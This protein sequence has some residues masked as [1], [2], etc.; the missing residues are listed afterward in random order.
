M[1]GCMNEVLNPPDSAEVPAFKDRRTGLIVFGVLQI[2]FGALC[3]LM[4]LLMILGQVM[5]SKMGQ[6]PLHLRQMIPGA[7][8]YAI[9]AAT[10][11]VLGIGSCQVR[12]GARALSLVVSWSW[13]VLGVVSL[14]AMIL[15]LPSILKAPQAQ[16][17]ALPETAKTIMLIVSLLRV[18]FV[19]SVMAGVMVRF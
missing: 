5:A 1:L 11:V 19:C 17:Q 8:F 3:V 9:A 12:R 6:A 2:L 10:L 13:L 18:S 15:F 4:I 7:M 14:A 16:G